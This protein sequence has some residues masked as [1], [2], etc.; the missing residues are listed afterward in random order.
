MAHLT[1]REIADYHED[2]MI[3]IRGLFD[4]E[5]TDLLRRAMEEDPAIAAHSLL[6][7]DQEGGATRISLWNRAGDSVYGL[8]AR[9]RKI[10]DIAEALIGEPVYHF[11]SKLTAK[12]PYVGG[13]WEWHQDFGYWYGAF[14]F[15][16]MGSCMIAVDRASKANGCLQV[17]KASHKMGRIEHGRFG[18]Q[19]GADPERVEAASALMDLVYVELNPGD[20]LFFHSN[21]L[22]RSDQNTSEHPRWS[23]ICCYNTRHN[24]P[25][26]ASH[27]PFYEPLEKL[28]DSAIREMGSKMFEVETDFWDPAKDETVGAGKD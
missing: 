24:N 27:H 17:L 16:D 23:L 6:R 14:L 4:A 10:V 13:A 28:P 9:S 15:P 7:A 5:E 12:D 1:S 2:G 19:T 22:H 25:Y 21:L 11:Q 8:A 26:K 18:D 20:T 3:F